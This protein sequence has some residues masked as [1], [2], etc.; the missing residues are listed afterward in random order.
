VSDQTLP[1]SWVVTE[2]GDVCGIH[3]SR[4]IPINATERNERTAGKRDSELFPYFGATGE[5]GK[6]DGFLFDGEY[7]LIGED[8]APFLEPH[9]GVSYLVSG[10]FWVNNHAHILEHPTSNKFLC[11]YLRQIDYR[12]FV[13]GT[14]R[15]KLN[16]A[17][18]RKIPLPLPPLP[19]QKRI[20]AKIEELFSELEAG[21]E[22]LRVARRQLGVYR[23]SL[24]KQAFEGK[25]TAPW[26]AENPD[27]LGS[28]ASLLARIQSARQSR[29]E[30]QLE[31]W[32]S[33]SGRKPR[34]PNAAPEVN[35]SELPSLPSPWIWCRLSAVSRV[36][37]GVTPLRSRPEYYK[38]GNVPWITST[39]VNEDVVHE[40]NGYVTQFALQ[41]TQL[42]LY[43]AGSLIVALYGEGKTRGKVSQ[44]AF[45]TTTNQALAVL[46]HE[47]ECE[48]AIRPY[49]KLYLTKNYSD[50]RRLSSGGVQ[51]NLNL[52]LIEQLPVPLCSLP[53]QQEIVRLLDEQFEAIER[54]ER[55]ID[56]A[57][58]RSEALRQAILHRAFTGC[59]VPQ[60]AADEPA[61]V[62]LARLRREPQ[63]AGTGKPRKQVG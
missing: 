24:L 48:K 26:R 49:L 60:D 28:P 34:P 50:I 52:G 44:V 4:R 13:T 8:G 61:S 27:K 17:Q 12:P 10:K 22:S 16:Q 39:V 35:L 33:S 19:E 30:Q 32:K 25:L 1:A 15:L 41:D 20:V 54:S 40:P 58:K 37:T 46:V 62:L 38:D 45:D 63:K 21:E 51:P 18:L 53:E 57:L 9:R 59:L 6:I 2:L 5:V 3:D 23:Q 55:E 36:G 14:T 47:E 7:V 42:Q 31:E 43:P 56:A 11:Y 29:Y